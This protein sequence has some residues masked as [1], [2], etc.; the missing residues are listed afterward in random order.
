MS[1]LSGRAFTIVGVAPEDFRGINELYG[2]DL[3]T[4][5]AMYP[6]VYPAPAWVNRRRASVFSVVGRSKPNVGL[7]QAGGAM[8]SLAAELPGQ[9]P[10]ENGGRSLKLARVAEAALNAKDRADYNHTG[11][12]LLAISGIVLLIACANV[13]NLLLPRAAGRAQEITVRIAIGASRLHLVRQLL[14]ESVLLSVMGGAVGR[15]NSRA[16]GC[17]RCGLP[18]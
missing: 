13:A 5:M 4:P 15:P 8:Q 3:W 11:A 12:I 6:Q 18:P 17:G 1:T 9:Y 7:A 2:A 10:R 16:D 14:V